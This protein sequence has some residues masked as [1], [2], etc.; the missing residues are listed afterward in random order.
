[1]TWARQHITFSNFCIGQRHGA[2]HAVLPGDYLRFTASA[3]ARATGSH[4]G[5]LIAFQR[6]QQR[7]ADAAKKGLRRLQ[8]GELNP[9]GCRLRHRREELLFEEAGYARGFLPVPQSPY[10]VPGRRS[11]QYGSLYQARFAAARG[12][13]VPRQNRAS[14]CALPPASPGSCATHRQ[15]HRPASAL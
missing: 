2:G 7:G 4:H 11:S 15:D 8:F 12:S 9:A 14:R 3:Y 13:D 5:H 10:T 1:M 6:L